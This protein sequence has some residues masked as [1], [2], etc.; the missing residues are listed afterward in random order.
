MTDE[1]NVYVVV[2]RIDIPERCPSLIW[3]VTFLLLNST[4]QGFMSAQYNTD[5]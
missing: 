1:I 2:K 4:P 5:N 3:N